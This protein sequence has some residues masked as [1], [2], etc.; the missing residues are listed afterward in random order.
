[1]DDTSGFY[2]YPA[3]VSKV[4]ASGTSAVDSGRAR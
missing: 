4:K 1:M 2:T 3:E